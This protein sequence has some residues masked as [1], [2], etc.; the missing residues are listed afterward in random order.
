MGE[1]YESQLRYLLGV[2]QGPGRG[3]EVAEV[4]LELACTGESH[5]RPASGMEIWPPPRHNGPGKPD[6]EVGGGAGTG[7]PRFSPTTGPRCSEATSLHLGVPL[8]GR[9]GFGAEGVGRPALV[10]RAASETR[11][12]SSPYRDPGTVMAPNQDSSS[13]GQAWCQTL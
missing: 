4:G 1:A 10:S 6:T 2:A 13:L 3:L 9:S 5:H 12:R 11:A 7:A 8:R